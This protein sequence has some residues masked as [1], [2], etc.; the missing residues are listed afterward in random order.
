MND[1]PTKWKIS[2]SIRLLDPSNNSLESTEYYTVGFLTEDSIQLKIYSSGLP[3]SKGDGRGINAIDGR[4][5]VLPE[6]APK[7]SINLADAIG[8]F[9]PNQKPGFYENVGGGT[10]ITERNPVSQAGFRI[11][12]CPLVTSSGWLGWGKKRQRVLKTYHFACP[13]AEVRSRW[14][15]AIQNILNGEPM[16]NPNHRIYRRLKIF[17]NPMSGKKQGRKIFD[18]IK[19]IL[20]CSHLEYTVAETTYAG[21]IQA[22]L[23][24]LD[25]SAIDEIVLV[26]GDGSI[27]EAINGLMSRSDWQEAI[28]KPI[29]VIPAGTGN[30]L[31]KTLLE[32]AG[33]PYDP[34]SAAFLIAKGKQR[35][36][37]IAIAQQTG[38]NYYSS[39]YSFLSL[40]WGII[41]DVDIESERLRFLGSL[42]TDIYALMRIWNLRHYP[43]RFSYIPATDELTAADECQEFK[44]CSSAFFDAEKNIPETPSSLKMSEPS[45]EQWRAIEDDFVLCW[46]MNIRYATHD[47]QAAPNA[48]LSDG[49]LDVILVRRGISKFNLLSAFLKSAQGEH[50]SLPGIE[51]YKVRGFRL[52]PLTCQGILAVDGEQVDYLPIQMEVKR[53]LARV[54]C[55]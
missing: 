5:I 34:V 48:H 30:G 6:Y 26:G 22:T 29:G 27:H 45:G 35:P 20:D 25:L 42:R 47:I 43:G 21:E 18:T 54:I 1:R 52:E 53:G 40:G 51:Y 28:L 4:G 46:A 23:S 17:I 41:S 33:E 37:D 10:E 9:A 12:T 31:A 11:H 44:E 49:N 36:L 7:I 55:G 3:L 39:Y 15:G 16:D 24:Q 13:N 38:K 50:I 2:E 14:I 19:P 8:V 32:I